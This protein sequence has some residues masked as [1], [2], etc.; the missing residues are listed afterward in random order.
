MLGAPDRIADLHRL[1]TDPPADFRPA[2]FWFWN[3]RIEN[4]RL[5]WQVD[6]MK[7]AGMGGYVMHGRTGLV[8]PYLSKEWFELVAQCTQKGAAASLRPWLYDEF[9]WPSGSAGGRVPRENNA[10][11][12][13]Y[14]RRTETPLPAGKT[15]L[16]AA[17]LNPDPDEDAALVS[18]FI[19][20]GDTL[21]P[22]VWEAGEAE[23][24]G[25]TLL[26]FHNI[27][28]GFS[29]DNLSRGATDRFIELTHDAYAR[30][31]GSA[32][33]DTVRHI[34]MDE[35]AFTPGL[36]AQIAGRTPWTDGFEDEFRRRRGYDLLPLLPAL[37]EDLPG[38]HRI[39][40]DYWETLTEL[41]R[42]HFARPIFEW[43][44]AHGIQ[45]TGHFEFETPLKEQVRSLGRTMAHYEFQQLPGIDQLGRDLY[46]SGGFERARLH[47]QCM[48]KQAASVARQLRKPGVMCE[49]HGVGGFDMGLDEMKTADEWQMALGVNLIVPHASF[50]SLRGIRKRDCP[51]PIDWHQP[52][53]PFYHNYADHI[54]RVAVAL[55]GG[56]NVCRLAVLHPQES[57][58]ATFE[59]LA[60][61]ED[62]LDDETAFHDSAEFALIEKHF[63]FLLDALVGAHFECDLVDEELLSRHGGAGSEGLRMGRR[64]Y[65]TLIVPPCLTLRATTLELLQAFIAQGGHL[66]IVGPRPTLV[67][68]EESP[69][70]EA[71]LEDPRTSCLDPPEGD[72]TYAGAVQ[73]LI[74]W[75][76]HDVII[77]DSSGDPLPK[78][79][80]HHRRLDDADLYFFT[81]ISRREEQA[82]ITLSG[83]SVPLEAWDLASGAVSD[84][85]AESAPEG[86]RFA[87]AFA[88]RQSYVL[89]IRDDRRAETPDPSC[90]PGGAA[91]TLA[92]LL[93]LPAAWEFSRAAPNLLFLEYA[94]IRIADRV[95]ERMA[96]W[97]LQR[98]L[99][100]ESAAA[101]VEMTFQF[102]VQIA[103]SGPVHLA[104]ETPAQ[105]TGRLNGAPIDFARETGGLIGDCMRLIPLDALQ[106]GTNQLTLMVDFQPDTDLECPVIAGPF[107][108]SIN[109]DA[110]SFSIGPEPDRLQ[111]GSWVE[112]GYP[113]Y[114][115]GITY[116]ASFHLPDLPDGPLF[117]DL[118]EIRSAAR[119]HLNGQP[120]GDL[121]WPPY[122]IEATSAIRQGEND[123]RIEVCN[124][125]RNLYGPHHLDDEEKQS[126]IGADK[127]YLDPRPGLPYHFVPCGLL[128]PVRLERED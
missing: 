12:K 100:E 63:L 117:L 72:M 115:G 86:L 36:D 18:A 29:I 128:E 108:V 80:T 73:Q 2:P 19:R 26:A 94:D 27:R 127:F 22:V 57:I 111:I 118:G 76:L 49:A 77:E 10:F 30:T 67:D 21:E 114:A 84:I 91:Q 24:E 7:Q 48:V 38:H 120:L 96:I 43:C 34:F 74:D 55:A 81:N 62:Y 103:P 45:F 5:A 107:A 98:R 125:L 61:K 95:P 50:Y 83:A 41:L 40:R 47:Y 101:P 105:Y 17:E 37:Y 15:R 78:L 126:G 51:P 82:R 13:K 109:N 28:H 35:A 93:E 44:E 3:D 65:D 79:M 69:A 71:L 14:L 97:E 85:A 56:E 110:R 92:P 6:Q 42:D 53:W 8:T 9:N 59:P 1:F 113:F 60:R 66:L 33:G 54:G 68:C 32:L 102:E 87:L 106:T 99:S 89:V 104:I 58:M 122:R 39:R 112:Q 25:E 75:G 90:R 124:S 121:V 64:T 11:C 46:S 20:R 119:I 16:R 88:P 52:W 70:L 123:L 23:S 31:L 116:R 4:D